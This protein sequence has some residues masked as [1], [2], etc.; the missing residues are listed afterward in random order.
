[1]S[2]VSNRSIATS[3]CSPFG[4]LRSRPPTAVARRHPIEITEFVQ[5]QCR[6]AE[7][8]EAVLRLETSAHFTFADIRRAL[9][10]ERKDPRDLHLG[11]IA[12]LFCTRS[13]KARDSLGCFA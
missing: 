1:M 4:R 2:R 6:A 12:N 10:R 13:A 5:I 9:Q 11:I 7:R 3:L 8:D